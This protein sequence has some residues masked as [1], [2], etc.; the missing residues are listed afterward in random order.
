IV[1]E[2]SENTIEINNLPSIIQQR[3]H[4]TKIIA[5]NMAKDIKEKIL[6]ETINSKEETPQNIASVLFN[7]NSDK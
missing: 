5:G 4:T 1:K 3:L 6:Q 7:K 2:I